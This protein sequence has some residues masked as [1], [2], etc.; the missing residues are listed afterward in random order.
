VV[1]P[2]KVREVQNHHARP[3][4]VPLIDGK[5]KEVSIPV[6]GKNSGFFSSC[7]WMHRCLLLADTVEK[8]DIQRTP[9]F[10]QSSFFHKCDLNLVYETM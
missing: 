3:R 1:T 10:S 5:K 2:N 4:L 7:F 6:I 8:L 9:N